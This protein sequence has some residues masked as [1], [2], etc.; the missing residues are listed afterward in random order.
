MKRLRLRLSTIMLL[1]VIVAVAVGYVVQ[2][3]RAAEMQV[4]AERL[5]VEAE[6]SQ[7]NERRTFAMYQRALA[8]VPTGAKQLGGAAAQSK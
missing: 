4:R 2:A 1:V 5:R 6:L 7:A 8:K 3:R